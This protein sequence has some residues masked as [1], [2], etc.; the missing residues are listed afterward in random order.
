MRRAWT[1]CGFVAALLGGVGCASIIKGCHQSVSIRSNPSGCRV[2]V[3]DSSGSVVMT[4]ATPCT[5]SLARGRGF[6]TRGNYQVR[7][8]NPGYA[9]AEINVSGTLGGWYIIGNLF[10]GGLIGWLIVDPLTGAMWSLGPDPVRANLA[11]Q[12]SSPPGGMLPPNIFG[13]ISPPPPA[14]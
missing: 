5:V 8:E 6:F 1:V 12:S 7:F 2:T 11:P 10:I 3:T 13:G 14:R 4:Q 9:P